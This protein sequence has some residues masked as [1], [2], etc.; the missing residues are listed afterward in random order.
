[1]KILIASSEK[2][3]GCMIEALLRHGHQVV[4]VLSPFKGIYDR[5]VDGLRFKINKMRGWDVQESCRKHNLVFRVTNNLN[6]GSLRA[7]I[8]ERRPD[9]LLLFGW[10]TLVSEETLA[11]FP[12]GGVN[13]HPSLLPKL[14]GPDPL[15][16]I[17]DFED[18]A[19]GLTF[20]QVV[21][22]LDAGPI[23]YQK[24]LQFN[25]RDTYDDLY[26][27]VL[28]GVYRQTPRAIKAIES[29]QPP[30][31]QTG[32]PSFVRRFRQSMR[33]LDL[34][35]RFTTVRRRTQACYSH[36]A[37][38]T[39]IG[40]HL[41]Y[42]TRC[43]RIEGW[44]QSDR[45]APGTIHKAGPFTMIVEIADCMLELQG[46]RFAG[47]PRWKTPYF[48]LTHCRPGKVLGNHRASLALLKKRRAQ[49]RETAETETQA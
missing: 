12:Y 47:A 42:F 8:R 24:P 48:L 25:S 38:V 33:V 34:E 4:G 46:I 9:L 41:I 23:Y 21:R 18:K 35:D 15:F 22:E 39:S 43:A 27:R 44:R 32:R 10:P 11:S 49:A 31:P 29:G 17:I 1:M 13:I 7:F 20:H 16:D 40:N 30:Q 19:F 14:R 26:L 2:F 37:R 36:H 45:Q 3:S 6:D 5:Q 28:H